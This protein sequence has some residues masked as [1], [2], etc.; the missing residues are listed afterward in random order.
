MIQL[1]AVAALTAVA[2][3]A[4]IAGPADGVFNIRAFGAVDDGVTDSTAAIQRAIDAASAK[5]GV[6]FI[7]TGRWLCKGH[8]ELKAGVHIAGVNRGTAILG[9]GDWLDPHAHRRPRK[10]GRA[11]VHRDAQYFVVGVAFTIPEQ[12]VD[13]IRW[14]PSSRCRFA[15][16]RRTRRLSL[17]T[18]RFR[19]SP[20][21]TAI[22]ES[23]QVRQ[24]T[25]VTASWACMG[26]YC[27]AASLVDWTGDIGRIENVQ[28]HSHFWANKAY[29]GDWTKV[30]AYMQTHL[31]AFVFGRTD[32]EY[33]TN[34][35][36]FPAKVGYRFIETANGAS[37]GQFSGIGADACDTAVLVEAV[38]PQGL[39]ITNGE[40]N[41]HRVVRATQV[42]IEK[43]ARGNVRFVNCGFWGPVEHNAMVRGDGYTSF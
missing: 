36:V 31:E 34:T 14:H 29:A 32:W 38:Q 42:V 17:S 11:A 43:T 40:F 6:V 28:F 8:F 5:G 35:F 24:R 22:T 37:N 15:Q 39:L 25:A 19:T 23:E 20:S 27:G 9:A 26:R 10:R 3:S 41:S 12:K 16:T 2:I 13:D 33:V 18:A 21:S 30:F 1:T 4:Q 7:P